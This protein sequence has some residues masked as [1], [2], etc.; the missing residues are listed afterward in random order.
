MG[1]LLGGSGAKGM[2]A[3]PLKLLGGGLSP[4]GPPSSYAYGF[5][6]SRLTTDRTMETLLEQHT[7]T[8]YT[9]DHHHNCFARNEVPIRNKEIHL[10]AY[11]ETSCDTGA[12][13]DGLS[14]SI[15]E[16]HLHKAFHYHPL[17]VPIVMLKWT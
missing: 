3:P 15:N 5:V 13:S 7:H 11:H 9:T 17:I 16:V 2:L 10:P 4:P 14:F 8:F 12:N 1:G 6:L